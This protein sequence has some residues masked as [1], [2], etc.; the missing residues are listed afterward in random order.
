MDT[1]KAELL[2]EFFVL[3]FTN[4]VFQ[5]FTQNSGRRGNTNNRKGLISLIS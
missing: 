5:D 3:V 1:L 2:K 4:K